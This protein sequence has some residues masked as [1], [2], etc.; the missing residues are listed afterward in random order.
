MLFAHMHDPG[1]DLSWLETL[2]TT[3][4][5]A[6]NPTS[7]SKLGIILFDPC[8]GILFCLFV[9][10]NGEMFIIACLLE[11]SHTSTV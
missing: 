2:C 3:K 7:F 8:K 4:T 5:S 11:C 1:S 6:L 10:A 9:F